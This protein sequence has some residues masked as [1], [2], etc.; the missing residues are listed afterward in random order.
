MRAT[1]WIWIALAAALLLAGAGLIA[2][3]RPP[4]PQPIPTDAAFRAAVIPN[5]MLNVADPKRGELISHGCLACH[6][7]GTGEKNKIGPNLFG[8]VGRGIATKEGFEY[9][10]AFAA[11]RG[12]TWTTDEL[13][14]FFR[15]PSAF[16]PGTKMT[17]GG[18][19]DPQDRMDLI[20]FLMTLR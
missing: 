18:L 5:D 17:F 16:A 15:D 6:N 19:G 7:L 9:S 1:K 20:A 11:L 8:V 12:R 10:P 2:F 4:P 13:Y 14:E 3:L